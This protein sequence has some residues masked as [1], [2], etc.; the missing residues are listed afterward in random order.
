[1]LAA[2]GLN[3]EDAMKLLAIASLAALGL[4]IALP[5][6]AALLATPSEMIAGQSDQMITQVRGPHGNRGMH[7]GWS[8]GH[9][10]GWRRGR[11]HGRR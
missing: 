8:R 4:A 2:C 7:R 11:G 5:A 9:H 6:G 10:Y 3:K 1:M